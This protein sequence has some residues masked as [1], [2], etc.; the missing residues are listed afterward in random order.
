MTSNFLFDVASKNDIIAD[1]SMRILGLVVRELGFKGLTVS[2][3]QFFYLLNTNKNDAAQLETVI[4]Q[5]TYR[6][7][8]KS[9]IL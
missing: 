9:H 2:L 4:M 1:L 6:A 3:I 7:G 8:S 5:D